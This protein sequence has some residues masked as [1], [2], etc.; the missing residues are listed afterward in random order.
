MNAGH[1]RDEWLM[2]QVAAGQ[3]EHLATLVRRYA[4]PLLTFI[5]RMIG[6]PHR[7]EDLFQEVFLS[8]WKNRR[9]YQFPRPFR[10]WLFAIAI[11]TC[12]AAFRAHTAPAA[13]SMDEDCSWTPPAADPSPG[14]RITATETAAFVTAAVQRLPAGQRAVVVLR[15]WCELSYQEIGQMLGTGEATARSNMHHGLSA[16]REYLEPRLR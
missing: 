2:G 1:D 5:Q 14:D 13:L 12:R 7:S 8:V 11:N 15:I 10:P 3:Q 4:N 16:I 9:Q 6:D